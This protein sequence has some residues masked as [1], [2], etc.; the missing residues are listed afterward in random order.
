MIKELKE[1]LNEC[2][3]LN[4]DFYGEKFLRGCRITVLLLVFSLAI[5]SR[6]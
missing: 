1:L 3:Q 5:I 2:E 6:L 4:K